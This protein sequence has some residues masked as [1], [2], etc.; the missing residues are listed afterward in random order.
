MLD[1]KRLT[2]VKRPAVSGHGPHSG[3]GGLFTETAMRA[4]V[5]APRSSGIRVSIDLFQKVV[6]LTSII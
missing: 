4:Q 2:L 1:G 6:G 3:V 5:A